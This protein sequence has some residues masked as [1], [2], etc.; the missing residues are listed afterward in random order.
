MKE[1]KQVNLYFIESDKIRIICSL[2]EK[3]YLNN[4]KTIILS[5]SKEESGVIDYS[6]WTYG[7]KK[8]IPHALIED[9][10]PE[11]QPI[12]ITEKFLNLNEADLLIYPILKIDNLYEIL[13]DKHL[14]KIF[15]LIENNIFLQ[16][17]ITF[18]NQR[19]FL[20]NIYRQ[21]QD[22]KSEKTIW[23]KDN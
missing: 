15:L 21:S 8:F 6:L 1:N 18:L 14:A 20:F 13:Q 22:I 9:S 2:A 12:L 4:V 17:I 3:A 11:L 19:N 10:F 16:D 23:I 5:S 7:R